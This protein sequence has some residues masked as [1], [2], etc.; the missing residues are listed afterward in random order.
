MA[1]V[2]EHASSLLDQPDNM[3]PGSPSP[4]IPRRLFESSHLRPAEPRRRGEGGHD[5]DR[6]R[7]GGTE[8]ETISGHPG[9]DAAP[10]AS[11]GA[12]GWLSCVANPKQKK[13]VD[14]R[15]KGRPLGPLF[16]LGRHGAGMGVETE[17]EVGGGLWENWLGFSFPCYRLYDEPVP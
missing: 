11:V 16:I 15:S 7:P 12:R 1:G 17:D 13:N 2:T 9:N 3:A 8:C 6:E 4:L 14:L 10:P 5:F